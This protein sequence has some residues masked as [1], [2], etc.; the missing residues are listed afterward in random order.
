[1]KIALS[2]LAF[3]A[4]PAPFDV[5]SKEGLGGVEVALTRLAPWS[6][7]TTSLLKAYRRDLEDSG[8]EVS[9]LQAL[10][11]G[12]EGAALLQDEASFRIM[13]DHLRRVAA[14][15]AVLGAKVAV[16]GSPKQRSRGAL[17]HEQAFGL[18]RD[19]FAMIAA[20]MAEEGVILGLEPVPAAYGGDFL[21]SAEDVRAMVAAVDHH[22]LRVH[23]D[24]GCV[25]LGGD[26][27][28]PAIH[29]CAPVMAH[30]HAAEPQL[31][32]FSAPKS[33]HAAAAAALREVGYEG[34]VSIEML[35][36]GDDPLAAARTALQ[37]VRKTYG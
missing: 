34:W 5:L 16:F 21:P 27:V 15:G 32:D 35:P 36:G 28:G 4:G 14:W 8:L 7:L 29:A 17:D 13:A 12:V 26:D 22:G 23:L 18:G 19:R 11:F 20:A 6:D 3:P 31:G 10:L 33:D 9:S 24:T 2:N 30:F 37:F 25:F 1:V